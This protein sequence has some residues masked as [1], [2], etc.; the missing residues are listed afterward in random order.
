MKKYIVML[1]AVLVLLALGIAFAETYNS[2]DW[3]QGGKWRF[4]RP[5]TITN[6][7]SGAFPTPT[8]TVGKSGS[9]GAYI[10]NSLTNS[11][12]WS[13]G[14]AWVLSNGAACN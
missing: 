13:N 8:T 3:R 1:A 11:P 5:V 4:D 14:S 7:T 2:D 12:C 6:A 9:P 10:W